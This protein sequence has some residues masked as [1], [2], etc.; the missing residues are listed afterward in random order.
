MKDKTKVVSMAAMLAFSS[1]AAAAPVPA[2]VNLASGSVA[3]Y[4]YGGRSLRKAGSVGFQK[5][6]RRSFPYLR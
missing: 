5:L 6:L 1:A 3:V 4:D 2:Q